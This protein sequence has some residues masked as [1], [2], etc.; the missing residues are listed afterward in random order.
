MLIRVADG[1][2]DVAREVETTSLHPSSLPKTIDDYYALII[3]QQAGA[4]AFN[5]VHAYPLRAVTPEGIEYLVR[6]DTSDY[7]DVIEY[8]DTFEE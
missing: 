1:R 7:P 6:L 2:A 5:L 3:D 8:F 4:E